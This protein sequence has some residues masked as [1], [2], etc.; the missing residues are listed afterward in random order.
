M[1]ELFFI[2]EEEPE[3]G[4]IAKAVGE[5]I[6]TQGE[7]EQEIRDNVLDAVNCHFNEDEKPTA[8]HL[9]YIKDEILTY[10]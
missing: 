4:Y 2:V 7:N 10:A 1:R 8:I 6:F 9:H 3:G 5:S